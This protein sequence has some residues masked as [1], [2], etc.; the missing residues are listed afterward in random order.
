M[1]R[2]LD[3]TANLKLYTTAIAGDDLEDV[4][5]ALGYKRINLAEASYGTLAAQVYMRKYPERVRSAFLVDL[6]TP[7]FKLPL[8]FARAAQNALDQVRL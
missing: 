6:V 5:S 1:P 8:P 3:K 2:K 4:R 7:G